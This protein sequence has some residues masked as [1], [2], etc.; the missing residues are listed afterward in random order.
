MV[1]EK[2]SPD[3]NNPEAL[4]LTDIAKKILLTG[5][6]AVSMSDRIPKEA[7]NFVMDQAEKRKEDVIERLAL[8]VSRFLDRL[9]L[10][11]EIKKALRGLEIDVHATLRFSGKDGESTDTRAVNVEVKSKKR[12]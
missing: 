3:E 6:G 8:E 5:L 2:M 10:S 4:G 9:D 7:L 12:S 1:K 11:Q